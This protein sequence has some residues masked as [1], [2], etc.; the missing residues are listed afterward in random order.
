M[1]RFGFILSLF[2]CLATEAQVTL[3]VYDTTGI[4]IVGKYFALFEDKSAALTIDEVTK[5][6]NAVLF[7][8]SAADIP[9]Y[10]ITNSKVW[11]RFKIVNHGSSNDWYLES[12]NGSLGNIELYSKRIGGFV[13]TRSGFDDPPDRRELFSNRPVFR[14]NLPKDS[15]SEFYLHVWDK[16]PLQANF[17]I[18]KLPDL[19]KQNHS[20]DFFH[21]AF[22]GLLFMLI[23]YNLFIFFSVRDRV[24]IYYIIYIACNAFFISYA[25]GYGSHLPAWLTY[26]MK[27]H[28]SWVP[29]LLG[30]AT[31]LFMINFLDLKHNLPGG[32]RISIGMVILLMMV[33]PLDLIGYT[34]IGV[35]MV[36][37][38]GLGLSIY[39]IVM[40]YKVFKKGYRPA[41]FYLI[42]FGFYLTGLFMYISADAQLIPFNS[43][44]HN[45]LEIGTAFEAILL[46]MAVGDKI[47][48]FK[49]EKEVAQEE[50]LRAAQENER[51]VREQNIVLE[52]K[53]KERTAELE[54]QKALV[55]EK[56][57]DI[58][59]S[60]RYAKRI[61]QSLLPQET[62]IKRILSALQNKN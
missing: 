25:N 37:V 36:Q 54:L 34:D 55:E 6:E 48:N 40:A 47:S 51:L 32:Y 33:V 15:V 7:V 35:L 27:V 8:N 29:F 31:S 9:N 2:I 26:A 17:S 28:P 4:T 24:F 52:Q 39:S 12:S 14:L 13:L 30:S 1:R 43:F 3:N 53:V 18:A 49:R 58:L 44:T 46:S 38:L 41:K 10:N 60:I 56:N 62:F 59:D 16:L 57:K 11:C 23:I 5:A 19:I 45:A 61:Q 22:Y 20:L 21:G 42:A 50:A